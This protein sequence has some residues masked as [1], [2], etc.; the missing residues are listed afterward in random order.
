MYNAKVH[1]RKAAYFCRVCLRKW[2][3]LQR[4]LLFPK[5]KREVSLGIFSKNLDQVSFPGFLKTCAGLLSWSDCWYFLLIIH[6]LDLW[7]RIQYLQHKARIAPRSTD[8][9]PEVHLQT[10]L[11]RDDDIR[12]QLCPWDICIGDKLFR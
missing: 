3:R 11:W 2:Q 6:D 10:K 9:D 1:D 8:R 12:Y 4:P 5:G 7:I